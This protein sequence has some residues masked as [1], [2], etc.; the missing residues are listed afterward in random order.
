MAKFKKIDKE[1][2][3]TNSKVNCYGF[4]LLTAGYLLDEYKKNP[5]GYYMHNRDEG[6]LVRWEDFRVDGDNVYAKP[7]VNLSHPKGQQTVDEIEGGF[8]NG[9]SVGHY[10]ILEVSDDP[11]LKLPGQTGITVTKWYNRETSLVDIPG[12]FDSLGLF[13]ENDN[14]LQLENLADLKSNT[15]KMKQLFLTPEQITKLNL[16]ADPTAEDVT[17]AIENL[18]AEA[19]KVP[20]LTAR[21]QTAETAKKK[22][23][24]DLKALQAS[25]TKQKVEDLVADAVSK[26]KVTKAAGD[27]LKVDY[28]ANPDGLANL[29]AAMPEYKP[30]TE[31]IRNTKTAPDLAAK[32]WDELDREGQL[33]NLKA[34]N[35]EL[36]K[37]KYKAQFGKDYAG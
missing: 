19:A 5:I 1:F 6:V 17:T 24:D 12:N 18:Q 7:V 31:Q 35:I 4:R 10:V 3:L 26:G 8:L 9:A 15:S 22:A 16:K 29:L 20:D 33:E 34:T 14:P 27:A 23:E 37:E 11:A 36:F 25:T 13:D 21:L 28:A 32:S 30:V 2:L